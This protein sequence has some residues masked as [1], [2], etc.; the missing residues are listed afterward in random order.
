MLRRLDELDGEPLDQLLSRRETSLSD[1]LTLASRLLE[2]LAGTSGGE[3]IT[4]PACSCRG[5]LDLPLRLLDSPPGRRSARERSASYSSAEQARREVDQ[6]I[7]SDIFAV[8]YIL[9]ECLTGRAPE[10]GLPSLQIKARRAHK[11]PEDLIDRGRQG[12]GAR[13]GPPPA[14]A[15]PDRGRRPKDGMAYAFKLRALAA[16]AR[17]TAK[18]GKQGRLTNE[19]K[20]CAVVTVRLPGGDRR[21][22]GAG[23]DDV[24][25]MQRAARPFQKRFVHGE[26]GEWVLAVTDSGTPRDAAVK[27]ARCALMV[28]DSVTS[29]LVAV[30]TGVAVVRAAR[31]VAVTD[32]PEGL[33]DG[34]DPGTVRLDESAVRLLGTRF[35]LARGPVSVLVRELV[36]DE[37]PRTVLGKESPIVGRDRGIGLLMALWEEVKAESVARAVLVSAVAGGGKTR[38]RHE[39]LERVQSRHEQFLYLIGRGDSVRAGAPFTLLGPALRGAVGLVGGEPPD[40]QRG[41]LQERVASRVATSRASQVAAF[42][43]EISASRFP[44]TTSLR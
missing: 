37:R 29:A 39:F 8:G 33:L 11:Q 22:R 15:R 44:T 30:S 26:K 14:D 3:G 12:Q 38:L 5:V 41:R 17:G 20:V 9:H 18:P 25:R 32:V 16:A 19:Q 36:C 31:T 10:R 28:R 24:R 27:A 21:R 34:A 42:L 23:N 35:E 1:A 7:R 4:P 40:I 43:G 13:P 2:D 6:D